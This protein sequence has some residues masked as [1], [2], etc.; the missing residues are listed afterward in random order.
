MARKYAIDGLPGLKGGVVTHVAGYDEPIEPGDP[1]PAGTTAFTLTYWYYPTLADIA[2]GATPG[3]RTNI[4]IPD[5]P[6]SASNA[7]V[8]ALIM[9][10]RARNR[11]NFSFGS[12][13]NVYPITDR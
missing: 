9:S 4:E 8:R 1:L 12:E 6:V 11:E 10:A 3:K 5:I 13:S 2:A 7:E